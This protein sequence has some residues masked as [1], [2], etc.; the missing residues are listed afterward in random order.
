MEIIFL[1]VQFYALMFHN[2][3]ENPW[4]RNPTR[5][6]M[7]SCVG[8]SGWR[9]YMKKITVKG[10]KP[11]TQGSMT[12]YG[13]GVLT[14]THFKTLKPW[15]KAIADAYREED[16]TFYEQYTPVEIYARFFFCRAKSSKLIHPSMKGADLDKLCR[17]LGDALTHTAYFDDSQIVSWIATKEYCSDPKF[18]GVEFSVRKIGD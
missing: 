8:P 16:G 11:V 4:G 12:A 18:E 13:S 10:I 6:S 1:F 2:G 17:G 7:P 5:Y 3:L 9:N 15:R 14:D